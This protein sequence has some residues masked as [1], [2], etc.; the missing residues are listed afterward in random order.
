MICVFFMTGH[1]N[2]QP[3]V[4]LEKPGIGP[5]TPGLQG[6]GLPPTSR[7]LLK[8]LHWLSVFTLAVPPTT[9]PLNKI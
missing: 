7:R 1:P 3:K 4:I 9:K 2:A 8:L 5:A 6:I